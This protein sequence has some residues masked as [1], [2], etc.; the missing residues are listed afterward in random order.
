MEKINKNSILSN[1]ANLITVLGLASS[2]AFLITVLFYRN[3]LLLS[4]IFGTIAGIS[5]LLDGWIA[6]K[7]DIASPIGRFLDQ[8]RDRIFI[9]PSMIILAWHHRWKMFSIPLP[10]LI[11]A[12][13]C[14]AVILILE[15]AIALIWIKG[16]K[17]YWQ[18]KP[19]DFAPNKWGK[20]KMFTGFLIVIVWVWSLVIEQ[21]LDADVLKFSCL[22]IIAGMGLMMWFSYESL[23]DYYKRIEPKNK[24]E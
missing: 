9:F 17:L 10:A 8:S 1:L 11:I 21:Y 4:A 22:S 2:I 3:E 24:I 16:I 7:L 13:A 5:D 23:R 20:R 15:L 12:Q 19:M 6:R 18:G 14:I